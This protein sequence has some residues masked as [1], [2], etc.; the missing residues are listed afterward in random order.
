MPPAHVAPCWQRR[1]LYRVLFILGQPRA[2]CHR[3][4]L[5]CKGEIVRVDLMEEDLQV[6]V[7]A[8]ARLARERPTWEDTLLAVAGKLKSERLYRELTDGGAALAGGNGA[9]REGASDGG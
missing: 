3:P 6:L 4:R 9:S 5:V 8:L 7:I 1:T 2:G